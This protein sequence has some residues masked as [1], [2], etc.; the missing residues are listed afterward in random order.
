MD[1][2]YV[3]VG[4]FFSS[5]ELLQKL[6]SIRTVSLD[7]TISDLH[8]TFAYRPEEVDTSLFGEDIAVTVTGYGN[9]GRNEGVKV[10]LSSDDPRLQLMI[11]KITV[12][13]IT[14]SVSNESRSVYTK[15]LE[16]MPI[17][18]IQLTGKFGGFKQC[19]RVDL[20][21]KEVS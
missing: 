7:R 9:N 18:P 5:D 21:K 11:E 1:C 17:D 6:C 4:C 13:H 10:S 19:G 12:P 14:L 2:K 16:F 20:Q 15:D 8:V 3:Y